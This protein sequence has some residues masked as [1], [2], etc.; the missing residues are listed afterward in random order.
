MELLLY[1][2]VLHTATNKATFA[3]PFLIERLSTAD[4]PT[5]PLTR[6][7]FDAVQSL[8][9]ACHNLIDSATTF[10]GPELIALPTLLYAPRIAQ[11]AQTLLRLH[12]AI[13][14]SGN[15][16]GQIIRS[17]ELQTM[18]YLEKCL[19]LVARTAVIDSEA[20]IVRIVKYANELKKWMQQYETS[21]LA[22]G[23]SGHGHAEFHAKYGEKGQALGSG[24]SNVAPGTQLPSEGLE[25][26]AD[27]AEF[28]DPDF[29]MDDFGLFDLFSEE[30]L[31]S[32][33][34]F[35]N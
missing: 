28:L 11:A 7:H 26:G 23:D 27:F 20:V 29:V 19:G 34:A 5:P 32:S 14:V 24:Y 33:A 4:V 6:H 35:D 10:T 18:E 9:T 3:A 8:K 25:N 2:P 30:D 16:Y 1:E 31:T 22:V 13:T 17:D 15:T 12:V 21:R